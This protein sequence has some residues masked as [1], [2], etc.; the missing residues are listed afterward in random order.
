[1]KI[2]SYENS[3]NILEVLFAKD[4]Q[5]A[6]ATSN[7]NISSV[8]FVDTFYDNGAFYIVSYAKSQKVQE[9]EKNNKISMC[10]KLYRFTGIA[11]NIGHP[12]LEKNYGIRA[13]L[14]KAFEPWYFKHNNENDE[15]MCYVKIELKQGFFYK[16]GTG[17]KVDFENRQAEE[18]TFTF[19][20]V[21]VD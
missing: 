19:D 1:M 4:Y 15:N 18:F 14:I 9:I 16:D 2:T 5:F 20:I 11:H 21:T 13:K 6:L 8:R 17:Y 10:N 3:L 7:D 12:L